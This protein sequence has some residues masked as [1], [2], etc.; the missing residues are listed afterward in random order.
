MSEQV[1]R[2]CRGALIEAKE[3]GDE[4]DQFCRRGVRRQEEEDAA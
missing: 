4:P 1:H 2:S 3:A